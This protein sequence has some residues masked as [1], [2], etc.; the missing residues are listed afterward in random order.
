M[1][2]ISKLPDLSVLKYNFES[3][4]LNYDYLDC[5]IIFFRRG[6]RNHFSEIEQYIILP[7]QNFIHNSLIPF[8]YKKI[9]K[10]SRSFRIYILKLENKMFKFNNYI[11]GRR[12]IKENGAATSEYLQKLKNGL[13][14]K[15]LEKKVSPIE[16]VNL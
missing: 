1:A 7:I 10:I 8:I 16:L 11:R 9:E 5:V 4:I 3:E 13:I 14:E 6:N 12:I 15:H 2:K